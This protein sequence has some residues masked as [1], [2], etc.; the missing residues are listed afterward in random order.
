MVSGFV[1]SPYDQLR[2]SSGEAILIWMKSKSLDRCSRERAKSIISISLLFPAERHREPQR[3][4]FLDQYVERL[5]DPRLRAVLPLAD[6]L[7]DPGTA[8]DVVA[9][10]REDLLEG[11]RGA[12]CLEGPDLHLPETLPTELRLTGEGLLRDERIGPD[13]ARMDLVVDQ[14]REL[15]HVD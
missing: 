6:G 8:G 3:L 15:Q 9:L 4:E 14:V 13:R 12:V 7:V 10:D 1:T 2:I 11:V 5:R